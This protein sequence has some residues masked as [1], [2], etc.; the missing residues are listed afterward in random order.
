MRTFLGNYGAESE[1]GPEVSPNR[2]TK[3]D[4]D[5]AKEEELRMIA[6]KAPGESQRVR[7]LLA[8]Q[9][10]RDVL[11]AEV[12]GA[13][14]ALLVFTGTND[15]FS[16][17]LTLLDRYLAT[18]PLTTIYLKDFNRLRFLRG[19][20]SLS[21]DLPGTV[22]ALREISKGLGVTR[23]CTTG[24]C[25]GGFAAIRYGVE[26]SADRMIAFSPPTWNPR[27][28]LTKFEE[29]RRFMKNRLEAA[30]PREMMDLRPVL[31]SR[32]QAGL[33]ELFYEEEDPRDRASALRLDRLPGVRLHPR[34]ALTYRL[35][36]RLASSSD[37]FRGLL[38]SLLGVGVAGAAE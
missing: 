3:D 12:K 2:A 30:V 25:V 14:T 28:P 32:A 20:Q 11:V 5:Y 4:P 1:A 24:N 37:D 10:E 31:E 17:P 35:V 16:M 29:G 13:D 33:I 38:A 22:A 34:P 36:R 18:L 15:E 23:V 6:E 19:I 27:E 26:L 8:A 9:P 7:P 21:D